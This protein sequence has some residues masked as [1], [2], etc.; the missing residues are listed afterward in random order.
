MK[1]TF[2]VAESMLS[3]GEL[4]KVLRRTWY[5]IVEQPENDL[6]SRF[7]VDRDVELTNEKSLS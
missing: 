6:A 3:R 5:H 4:T 7:R 2:R 1:T